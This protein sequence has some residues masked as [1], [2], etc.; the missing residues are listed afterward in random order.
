MRMKGTPPNKVQRKRGA[1]C[2]VPASETLGR[3]PR[4]YPWCSVDG[5]DQLGDVEVRKSGIE[6]LGVFAVRPFRAGQRIRQVNVIREIT[7]EAPLREDLGERGDHCA[8]PD[9]RVVL[10]GS[11]D[12]YVNHSCDPSAY[13]AFA[14]EH[15][16]L[17]ARR[18][19]PAGAEITCDY[20]INI[21][22]GSVWL[23]HCGASRCAG[24]VVGD[25]FLLPRAWQLEYRPMLAEW[26]V[27]RHRER[28]KALDLDRGKRGRTRR[29]R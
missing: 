9:G 18:D 16:Y 2:R 26:F 15:T 22:N 11:P 13:E 20:N 7:D 25:F 19:I 29:G 4:S 12:C 23:C 6:G 10:Y 17:V 1:A 8:Y 3:P 21:A 28:V 5:E 27:R 24:T 14:R